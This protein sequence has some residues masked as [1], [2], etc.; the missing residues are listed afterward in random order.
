MRRWQNTSRT[1]SGDV[2]RLLFRPARGAGPGHDPGISG[3]AGGA[4]KGRSGGPR[5]HVLL[6]GPRRPGEGRAPFRPIRCG[7]RA[8]LPRRGDGVRRA[9]RR[10]GARRLAARPR[11]ARVH[12]GGA[13][14]ARGPGARCAAEGPFRA[15]GR[16]ARAPPRRVEMDR[17]R[18]HFALRPRRPESH[19]HP[20]RRVGRR[21]QRGQDL[22]A[23]GV[24]RPRRRRRARHAQHQDGAAPLAPLRAR[25][26]AR[27]V[28]PR[29]HH[30]RHRR[31]CGLARHQDGPGAAEPH[32]GAAA[33]RHR[34]LDGSA[35]ARDRAALRGCA[36]RISPPRKLVLSQ[37]HL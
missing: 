33:A 25:G 5:R 35:R 2:H 36:R 1:D 12:R 11:A 6:P 22:A 30:P 26:P 20:H 27:R 32:Q 29:R 24:R 21:G 7:V 37:L 13:G 15:A 9:V 4:G 3:P 23:A 31:Q 18:R 16:A 19:R 28:R 8:G 34:R 17:H 10:R 14:E